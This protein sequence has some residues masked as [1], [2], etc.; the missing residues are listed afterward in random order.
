MKLPIRLLLTL[1]VGSI[2]FAAPA[3]VR[4][5]SAVARPHRGIPHL[6]GAVPRTS[7]PYET[8]ASLACVYQLVDDVV[9]GC[10]VLGTS[11]VPQGG[12]GLIAIVNA[13]NNPPP[14][15]DLNVFSKRFTLT[16]SAPSNPTF[17]KV[18]APGFLPPPY[19]S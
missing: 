18:Y 2:V 14:L 12:S 15:G 5:G 19:T 13:F 17:N 4:G 6:E 10:P 9:P 1:V 11:A 16:Q 8:P 7:P 3:Q